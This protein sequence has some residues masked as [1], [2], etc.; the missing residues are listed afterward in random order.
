MTLNKGLMALLNGNRNVYSSLLRR[1]GL[2]E[3]YRGNE[4]DRHKDP[5]KKLA[6]VCSI[7]PV[8]IAKLPE[9]NEQRQITLKITKISVSKC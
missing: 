9:K 8:H 2:Q 4:H 5:I 6:H 7:F 3:L 1:Y